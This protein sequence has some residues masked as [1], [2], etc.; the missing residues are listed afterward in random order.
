MNAMCF[1]IWSKFASMQRQSLD[2]GK[3]FIRLTLKYL[4]IF[5]WFLSCTHCNLLYYCRL[6]FFRYLIYAQGFPLII[7]LIVLI[8]DKVGQ[9]YDGDERYLP[10]MGLYSCFL[11]NGFVGIGKSYFSHPIF[12]YFQSVMLVKCRLNF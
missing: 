4:C 6:D 8:V 10:N 2:E 5:L 12:I 9:K 1:N 7:T 3:K 11:G